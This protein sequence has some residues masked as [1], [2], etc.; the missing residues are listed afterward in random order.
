M[1]WPVDLGSRTYQLV[2]S[3]RVAAIESI[4]RFPKEHI[5]KKISVNILSYRFTRGECYKNSFV[6]V[7]Y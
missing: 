7:V 5:L 3:N 2:V 4:T 6:A 1:E